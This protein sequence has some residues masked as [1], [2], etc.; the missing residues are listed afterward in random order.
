M[1]ITY[2]VTVTNSSLYRQLF[3]QN[4][5]LAGQTFFSFDNTQT[6]LPV[7]VRY[8]DFIEHHLPQDGWIIFCHQDFEFLQNPHD[9]LEKL[10]KNFIYGP[11]GITAQRHKT[12]SLTFHT[13]RRPSLKRKT[14]LRPV[15]YGQIKQG[16]AANEK[17]IG[18]YLKQP[19]TVDTLDCCCLIVHSA[20]IRKKNLRFDPQFDFH[21][22]SEDFSLAARQKNVFTKALQLN[23]RHY[24]AGKADAHFWA[25]Y[26]ALLQKYPQEIFLT[27][28]VADYKAFLRQRL[29]A[30]HWEIARCEG[31]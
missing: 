31:K 2:V 18:R 29:P 5:H 3:T 11:I 8:N 22:Y 28:C 21:L 6:N 23:C 9:I 1:S 27:T 4:K 20:L 15:Y 12:I 17:K 16:P 19:Q 13:W 25:K 7:P 24:S 14:E 26:K 30:S 10:D